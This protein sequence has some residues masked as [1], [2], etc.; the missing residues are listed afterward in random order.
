MECSQEADPSKKLVNGCLLP[1]RGTGWGGDG[2]GN[3]GRLLM[4]M[5][6]P[7]RVGDENILEA[8]DGNDHTILDSNNNNLQTLSLCAK[9]VEWEL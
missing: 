9:S 8:D 5:G 4:N 2:W 3:G 6:F 1:D 7:V